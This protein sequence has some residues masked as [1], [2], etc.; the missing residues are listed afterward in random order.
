MHLFVHPNYHDSVV[1]FL[2]KLLIAMQN[3]F[4]I[5]NHVLAVF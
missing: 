4:L 3:M 1:A 2:K 5:W